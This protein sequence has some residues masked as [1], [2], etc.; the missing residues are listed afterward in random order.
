VVRPE[1]ELPVTYRRTT[2][3]SG[4]AY[5]TRRS[6]LWIS[7]AKHL[8][9]RVAQAPK[10]F[11]F[12]SFNRRRRTPGRFCRR[13]QSETLSKGALFPMNEM[14]Q[15]KQLAPEPADLLR[16]LAA[17]R[18]LVPHPQGR[19]G[20]YRLPHK[21]DRSGSTTPTRQFAWLS[22]CGLLMESTD[23]EGL[24][25]RLSHHHR[26][27][28]RTPITPVNPSAGKTWGYGFCS[29]RLLPRQLQII[30]EIKTAAFWHVRI[31]L[32]RQ[33]GACWRGCR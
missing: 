22:S 19:A 18:T 14:E 20:G 10:A 24:G 29:K 7:T 3:G 8:R 13:M 28:Q 11:D 2:T 31:P 4:V 6:W 23:V 5:G 17:S 21:F 25:P 16:E 33:T 30:Y 32:P 12:A 27:H 1:L 15:G 9:A 26:Q